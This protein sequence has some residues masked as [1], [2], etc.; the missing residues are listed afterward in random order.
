ML[1]ILGMAFLAMPV[2]AGLMITD[3]AKI[4]WP[5]GATSPMITIKDSDIP[6][7]GTITIDTTFVY[8]MVESFTFTDA[9]VIIT[10][11]AAAALWT[12]SV[13]PAGDI[14]TLTSTGGPTVVD[15]TVTVTFT[16]AGGNPWAP[17]SWGEHQMP[18]TVKRTDTGETG[19][20]V[21]WIETPPPPGGLTV[22]DS[23]KITTALGATSPVIT[24]A[25]SDIPAGGTII[26]N[27]ANLH[28]YVASLALTD[29]NVI[30]SDTAVAATWT[31]AVAGDTLTLTS[32]GGPTVFGETVTVTFTGA[33]GNAW[34][35]NTH[36]E[37]T[38]PLTATRT[39][40]GQTGT[41]NFVIDI[42]P[43]PGY[44]VKANFGALPT[45]DIAPLTVRFYDISAGHPTSWEWDFGDFSP[46]SV[47]KNPIHIYSGVGTYTVSL[48]ATNA[49]G[50]D[51]K[52][53][54][55]YI[56]ALNGA[57]LTNN[58]A[59]NGLT[60]ANCGGPQSVTVDTSILSATLNPA[61]SVLEV[62]PL[63]DTGFRKIT[64]YALNG[65]FSQIG[66]L[67]TG[68]PI[69]VHLVSEEIA[70][71]GGFSPGIGTTASFNYTIDLPSYPCNAILSTK[72]WEG[73]IPE[74]DTKLRQIAAGNVPAAA[75]AGT[76]YTARI[77]TAN[78]PQA[79]SVK[80]HMSINSDWDRNPVL[81][82][83]PGMRFIWWI[84]DDGTVGQVLPT[85]Y[86]YTDPVENLDYYEAVSPGGLSTF[87][88]SSFTGNN[89]P[90][91]LIGLIISSRAN[92]EQQY[93]P[94]APIS[95]TKTG[96]TPPIPPTPTPLASPTPLTP[97]PSQNLGRTEKLYSNANGVITQATMLQSLDGFA[98][99]TIGTGVVA[100][101]ADG[102][103]PLS[104]TMTAIPADKLPGTPPGY[105]FSFAGRAYDIQPDGAT[106]SP[107]ISIRFAA[108]DK[109]FG[110]EFIVKTY[111]HATGTWQD[112]PTKYNPNDGTITAQV[113]HLCIF[114]LFTK[115]VTAQPAIDHTPAPPQVTHTKVEPISAGSSMSNF[116]GMF[117][118]GIKK[119]VENPLIVIGVITLAV[120]VFLYGRKR[121]RDRL[122]GLR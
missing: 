104:I 84:S 120:V 30:V 105:Q 8:L 80:L 99:V 55:N 23:A 78:F 73:V 76:A 85:T 33:G 5:L 11:D 102:K 18:L 32:A 66:N 74:Y 114:A 3:G 7:G 31:G 10:S 9:N 96:Q 29:A 58:T 6:D 34:V 87:G 48:T 68:N 46:I 52:T 106:F 89:N 22:A 103:P 53:Q 90:I 50:S 1:C 19:T 101:G 92:P 95:D 24:I 47:D 15:E 49:Y 97:P 112:V 39:D 26:M 42:A 119:L 16:G 83:G 116:V 62:Q 107:D 38:V 27:V 67:I 77:T 91:Q 43:P 94:D 121:R 111:D 56:S 86:L 72:I 108:P 41:F 65:G 100:H 4:T 37:Q 109:Q 13:S 59:I 61:K 82:A 88:L 44:T 54:Y 118:W 64:I 69:G 40:T 36:G 21:F 63:A 71:P 28:Q 75:V 51:T 57:V 117:Q 93:N 20:I 81:P 2:A 12:G 35:P 110:Q 70:P 122:M 113:S 98:T 45:S 25:D 14:L 115:T 79:A 17:D 60:I